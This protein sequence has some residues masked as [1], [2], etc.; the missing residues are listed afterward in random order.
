MHHIAMASLI[1][2]KVKKKK[3]HASGETV[4]HIQKGKC[5]VRNESKLQFFRTLL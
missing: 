2:K 3:T 5:E 1:H 4:L